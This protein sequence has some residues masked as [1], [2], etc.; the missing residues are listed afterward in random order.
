MVRATKAGVSPLLRVA[1]L[2]QAWAIAG[3]FCWWLGPAGRSSHLLQGAGL[4]GPYTA[5][6]GVGRLGRQ[7]M[8]LTHSWG[9][10]GLAWPPRVCAQAGPGQGDV[11]VGPPSG[12]PCLGT[13]GHSLCSRGWGGGPGLWVLR[14]EEA[15]MRAPL[16]CLS[17]DPRAPGA[18]DSRELLGPLAPTL[19][20]VRQGARAG[21]EPPG[22]PEAP[23]AAADRAG[24]Q[25][26]PGVDLQGG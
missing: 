21:G 14:S 26:L 12:A 19:Q 24:A 2:Q 9:V 3:S 18:L 4:D 20:R 13:E 15:S 6:G 1:A 7:T 17:L 23:S 5:L 11:E 8:P 10:D 22:L 16:P 25:R